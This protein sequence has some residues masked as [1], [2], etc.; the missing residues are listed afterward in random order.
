MSGQGFEFTPFGL[1]PLGTQA[2][3]GSNVDFHPGALTQQSAT[4]SLSEAAQ[5]PQ[6]SVTTVSRAERKPPVA[7]VMTPG[8]L[9]KAAK[10][11]AKDIRSELK[12]MKALQAE[13]TELER[14]I[15]AA[16][17]RPIAAVSNINSRRAV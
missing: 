3:L 7:S 5:P 12:R 16:K 2:G 9:L 13:L 4:P 1:V 6:P 11:R 10:S 15:A 17:G 14:L 8:A